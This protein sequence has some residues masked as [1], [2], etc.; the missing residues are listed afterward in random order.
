MRKPK[1]NDY[2]KALKIILEQANMNG[3]K[4]ALR[5]YHCGELGSAETVHGDRVPVRLQGSVWILGQKEMFKRFD[6]WAKAKDAQVSAED[7]RNELT[8]T[9][10]EGFGVVVFTDYVYDWCVIPSSYSIKEA[11]ITLFEVNSKVSDICCYTYEDELG[12][13][14]KIFKAYIKANG[15]N[16]KRKP[17]SLINAQIDEEEGI[18]RTL[19]PSKK[20]NPE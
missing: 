1:V 4:Y 10:N 20:E 2:Q 6:S 9:I 8:K 19:K 5:E 13:A 18:S 15:S 7:Y 16:I 12:K 3:K 14:V 11:E 17:I